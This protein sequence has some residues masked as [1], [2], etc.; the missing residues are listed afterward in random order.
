MHYIQP[1]SIDHLL[2][3]LESASTRGYIGEPISQLEH[4]LQSAKIAM[5]MKGSDDFVLAALFHD[6]GHLCSKEDA[7]TLG[8]YGIDGHHKFGAEI[9]RNLG[10]SKNVARLVEGHVEAKRYLVGK[11]PLYLSSLSFASQETL[12][13]QGGAMSSTE[14]AEFEMDP[15]F[16]DMLRLRVCDDRAKDP[17]G[18]VYPISYYREKI[19]RQISLSTARV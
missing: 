5:E 1:K 10:F 6:I 15:L 13:R 3:I 2:H 17:N 9:L 18:T 8:V 16:K 4:A 19:D 7:P 11:N 14:I 12:K